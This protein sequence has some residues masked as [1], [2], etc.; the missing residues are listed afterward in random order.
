MSIPEEDGRRSYGDLLISV[1]KEHEKA[2]DEIVERIENASK[3]LLE[4]I[5]RTEPAEK[6]I[7]GAAAQASNGSET[8][9]YLKIR[10]NRPV[11][12]IIKILNAL[13]E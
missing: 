2:L 11:D 1:L 6:K 4:A 5:Q 12:E 13:K 10:T 9:V 7:Y 8:L 3:R